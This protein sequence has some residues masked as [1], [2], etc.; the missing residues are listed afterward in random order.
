MTERLMLATSGF[1]E[2]R[3]SRRGFIVRAAVVGSALAVSPIRYLVRP[4]TAWAAVQPGDCAGKR[5]AQHFSEFCC[6]INGGL[7]S[8]PKGTFI[9]GFWKAQSPTSSKLCGGR[10]RYYIDCNRIHKADCSRPPGCANSSCNCRQTCN[11]HFSYFNC[12]VHRQH[13]SKTWVECRM[14]VCTNPC[15]EPKDPRSR[16]A[17]ANC[18]CKYVAVNATRNHD[19]CCACGQCS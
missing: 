14:V 10:A 2:R 18:R 17:Q 7:N 13:H 19:A 8:C 5:C 6:S 3:T 4:Q 1:L 9:G 11:I 15:K 12:N 16:I